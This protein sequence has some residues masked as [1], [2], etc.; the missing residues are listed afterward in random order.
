MSRYQCPECGYEYDEAAGDPHQG[1]PAGTAL[2]G[3]AGQFYLPGLCRA[4][5]GRLQAG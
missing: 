4:L 1:Y 3:V 2:G 5:Q